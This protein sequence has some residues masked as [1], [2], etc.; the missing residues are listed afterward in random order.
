VTAAVESWWSLLV[1]TVASLH[2]RGK[3]KSNKGKELANES[4]LEL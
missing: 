3:A 4:S 2:A 1:A